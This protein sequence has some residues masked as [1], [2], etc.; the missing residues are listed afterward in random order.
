M[1]P[2]LL[3]DVACR[4]VCGVGLWSSSRGRTSWCRVQCSGTSGATS[5]FVRRVRGSSIF[6]GDQRCGNRDVASRSGVGGH[7]RWVHRSC[8]GRA[9]VRRSLTTRHCELTLGIYPASTPSQP[10]QQICPVL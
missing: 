5:S 2:E 1:L 3:S 6:R 10:L 8:L 7:D 9:E 4:T